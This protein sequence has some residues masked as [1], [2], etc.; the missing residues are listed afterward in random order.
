MPE[1]RDGRHVTGSVNTASPA[2]ANV[3]PARLVPSASPLTAAQDV[4][5]QNTAASAATRRLMW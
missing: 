2:R 3:A 4:P 5:V 1:T